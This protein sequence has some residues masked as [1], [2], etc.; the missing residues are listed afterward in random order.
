MATSCTASRQAWLRWA[1]QPRTAPLVRPSA[2]PNSPC[3]PVRSTK[4]VSHGSLSVHRPSR[5]RRHRGRPNLVSSIPNNG[6]GGGSPNTAAHRRLNARCTVGQDSRCDR[7][8]SALTSSFVGQGANRRGNQVLLSALASERQREQPPLR[9]ARQY[10][11][12]VRL[13]R[14][15]SLAFERR[16]GGYRW[17]GATDCVG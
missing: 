17:R 11:L 3:A 7:A 8:T 2:W 14:T 4:P 16:V 9:L 12:K 15:G 10:H 13:G 1:S 6:V 5:P